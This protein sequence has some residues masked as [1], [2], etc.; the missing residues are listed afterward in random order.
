[1]KKVKQYFIGFW[2]L[3][4]LLIE[5]AADLVGKTWGVFHTAIRELALA[6][7]NEYK[8]TKNITGEPDR[9]EK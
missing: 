1:M 6:V 2:L 9:T 8:K 7:E 3:I 5:W 4:L